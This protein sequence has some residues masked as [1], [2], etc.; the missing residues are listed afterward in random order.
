MDAMER[1]GARALHVALDMD[2]F[3]I[4]ELLLERGAD[5]W[6]IDSGGA[7]LGS[8]VAEPMLTKSPADEAAQR[9]LS[10]RVHAIGWPQPAPSSREVR[11][12]AFS[13]EWPPAGARARGA[14]A[15]P[16]QVLRIIGSN[17]IKH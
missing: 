4:A 8:S 10:Q 11:Q 6:A 15:V 3:Q 14:P 5:P 7:N 17:I 9:R 12:L 2:R 13:G 16:A 1:T